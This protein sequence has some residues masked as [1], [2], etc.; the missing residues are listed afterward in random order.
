M[1]PPKLALQAKLLVAEAAL[2]AGYLARCHH[3][4]GANLVAVE[5]ATALAARERAS[6]GS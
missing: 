2:R 6:D 1:P 5:L 3:G 4:I